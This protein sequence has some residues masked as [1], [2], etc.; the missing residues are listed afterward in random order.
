MPARSA[1]VTRSVIPSAAAS[2]GDTA[3]PRSTSTRA[4]AHCAN[5]VASLSGVPPPMTAPGASMSAPGVEQGGHRLDV[6][7]AG[8]PVQGRLGVLAREARVDVGTGRDQGGDRVGHVR[9]VPGPVGGHVQ[10]GPAAVSLHRAGH[11]PRMVGQDLHQ[12]GHVAGA[13]GPHRRLDGGP[14]R[15]VGGGIHGPILPRRRPDGKP[16]ARRHPGT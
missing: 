13:H 4:A 5:A 3:A 14:G 6:V 15:G 9:Q 8:G 7:A 10:Q 2:Q 1:A 12:R 11:E 16:V